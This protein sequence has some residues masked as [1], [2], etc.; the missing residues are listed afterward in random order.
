MH[1]RHIPRTLSTAA[2][3]GGAALLLAAAPAQAV[4][5][6]PDGATVE[7]DSVSVI[8]FRVLDGCDGAATDAIE[9]TIPDSIR[10]VQPQAVPGWTLEVETVDEGSD[11]ERIT[12]VRWSGGPLPDGQFADFGMRARF[13]DVEGAIDFPT[14]QFCGL[15]E[16][17]WDGEGGNSDYPAPRAGVGPSLGARDQ[18]DLAQNVEA[19]RGDVTSLQEELSGADPTSVSN[20]VAGIEDRIP[21]LVDR[22]N[23]LADRIKALEE[24]AADGADSTG[25]D[26]PGDGS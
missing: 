20:R 19:L 10:N 7:R 21:E 22:M 13:P 9:V 14:T 15:T 24:A 18:V 4:I 11:A 23:R 12:S 1:I 26:A 3:A 2:V 6:I 8:T 5:N 16:V 17:R 25:T